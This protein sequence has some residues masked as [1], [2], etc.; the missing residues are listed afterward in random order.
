[1]NADLNRA[2]S[3]LHEV[4]KPPPPPVT[5]VALPSWLRRC[6]Y[7]LPPRPRR[8]A[9]ALPHVAG[10]S[11]VAGLYPRQCPALSLV[12][13]RRRPAR[14][15]DAVHHDVMFQDAAA[16][17]M[18]RTSPSSTTPCS[19]DATALPVTKTLPPCI[20]RPA[21]SPL[22]RAHPLHLSR[23]RTV[24]PKTDDSSN[25]YISE[26]N[27]VTYLNVYWDRATEPGR[28]F[29]MYHGAAQYTL[30]S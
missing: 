5:I 30:G 15:E 1:V 24:T 21:P 26:P 10:L 11:D 29:F 14:R 18:A 23:Q 13:G 4:T 22:S 9:A 20:Y 3:N 28:S 17:P 2:P 12:V 8:L 16:L 6:G 19:R 25:L 27:T 7:T